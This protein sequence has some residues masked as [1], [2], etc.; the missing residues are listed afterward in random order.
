MVVL[1]ID[2]RQPVSL[3][4]RR[5]S[6]IVCNTF[7][8]AEVTLLSDLLLFSAHSMVLLD[9]TMHYVED[10]PKDGLC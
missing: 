1:N 5:R 8:S 7:P 6:H 9:V 4:S 2:T 3:I 10:G